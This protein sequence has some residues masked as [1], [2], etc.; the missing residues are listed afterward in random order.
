MTSLPVLIKVGLPSKGPPATAGAI[1]SGCGSVGGWFWAGSSTSP[2]E[3]LDN[4]SGVWGWD[5]ALPG[6]VEVEGP[7]QAEGQDPVQ[8]SLDSVPLT[9]H[10]FWN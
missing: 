1:R 6:L 9:D 3:S 7:A 2:Y 10:G 5:V 8:R 4:S